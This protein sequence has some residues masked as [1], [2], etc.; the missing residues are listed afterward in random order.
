MP[1]QKCNILV[2]TD[3]GYG[4]KMGGHFVRRFSIGKINIT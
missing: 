4:V 2:F 1:T 3:T